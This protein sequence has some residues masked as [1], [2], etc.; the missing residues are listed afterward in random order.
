MGT[1]KNSSPI[2]LKPRFR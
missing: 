2:S 1:S